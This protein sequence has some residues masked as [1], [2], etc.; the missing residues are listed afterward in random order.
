MKNWHWC[1]A[2]GCIVWLDAG[3]SV[4]ICPKLSRA[5]EAPKMTE[6]ETCYFFST[7]ILRLW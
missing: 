3:G 1:G 6:K 4:H 7:I 2:V 5:Y